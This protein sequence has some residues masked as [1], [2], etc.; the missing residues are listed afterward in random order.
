MRVVLGVALAAVIVLRAPVPASAAGGTLTV[1][2]SIQAPAAVDASFSYP[3]PSPICT[4]GVTF[5]WDGAGWLAELPLR[6]GATCVAK[7]VGA[8][9]PAGHDGAGLHTVCGSAGPRFSDCKTVTI[10][11]GPGARPGAAPAP[12]PAPAGSAAS[13]DT[14]LGTGAQATPAP[15]SGQLVAV[16]SAQRSLALL[17][18]VAAVVVLAAGGLAAGWLAR[19]PRPPVRR[20]V[21]RP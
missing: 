14:A 12:A 4:A 7:A 15:A 21:P 17:A 20:G 16:L 9:P 11:A 2:A 8:S 13:P 19:R 18:L 10:L 1:P 6:T 3:E 5:T